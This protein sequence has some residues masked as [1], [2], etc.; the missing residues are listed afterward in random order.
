MADRLV[1]MEQGRVRQIGT[2]EEL[3]ESPADPF[4][5]GFVGR[6]NLIEG[7]LE[8]PGGFRASSGA[9]L[10]CAAEAAP[11]GAL[12]LA[13]RPERIGL[14]PDAAGGARIAAVTYL[15]AQTEYVVEQDGTRLMIARPTPPL[16]DPLRQLAVGDA[17]VL[18]WEASAAR[19]LPAA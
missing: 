8:A 17:V 9:L 13:L 7:R 4:V 6:C 11:P 10:H 18:S 1:V 5:A 12:L 3:Y 14:A 19:L 2:A 15:G 16:A